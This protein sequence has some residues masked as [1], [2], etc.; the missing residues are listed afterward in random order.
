M[1]SLCTPLTDKSRSS[2][3]FT[4]NVI[5]RILN[6]LDPDKGCGQKPLEMIFRYCFNQGILILSRRIEKK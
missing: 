5:K 1:P 2:F 4:A 3:Q 6:K